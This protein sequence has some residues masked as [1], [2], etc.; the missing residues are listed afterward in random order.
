MRHP[1]RET[2]GEQAS[3]ADASDEEHH[4]PAPTGL[5]DV[6]PSYEAHLPALPS[7]PPPLGRR[8]P[9]LPLDSARWMSRESPSAPLPT[10]LLTASSADSQPKVAKADGIVSFARVTIMTLARGTVEKKP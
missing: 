8:F 9:P 3:R 7:S 4:F 6:E 10:H 5:Q 1:S 2:N